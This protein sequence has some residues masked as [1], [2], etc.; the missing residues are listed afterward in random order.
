MV[1]SYQRDKDD[2][3]RY[4]IGETFFKNPIVLF[5]VRSAALALF[6]YALVYAFIYPDPS[7]NHFTTALFWSFFWP[8][9]MFL[10]LPTLGAYFCSICPLS[11]VG[12]KLKHVKKRPLAMPRFLRNPYIS[13][14]VVL[15]VYWGL[16]FA[17]PGV[18]SQ[19][20]AVAAFYTFFALMAFGFFYFFKDMSYCAYI[21]P[22]SSIR[23]AFS[24]ISF[25][26]LGTY[27]DACS[28]CKTFECAK[29]CEFGQSP[30]NFDR[31][32]SMA[33]CI[34]CMDC[35]QACEAVSFKINK[36]GFSLL[37]PIKRARAVDVWSYLLLFA[38][39][40]LTLK[41]ITLYNSSQIAPMLPWV[42]LSHALSLAFP[43]SAVDFE[44]VTTLLFSVG[45]T[46]MTV[47]A[48]FFAASKILDTAFW[49]LFAEVGYAYA[50]LPLIASF[51]Y[52]ATSFFTRYFHSVVNGFIEAFA[53]PFS[54]IEPLARSDAPWLH[55]FVVF[56][57]IAVIWTVWLIWHRVSMAAAGARFPARVFSALSLAVLPLGYMLIC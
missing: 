18:F 40:T 27:Q 37:S 39:M 7:D 47:F 34:L 19:P 12:K 55:Y 10:S 21:C 44:A 24:R 32:S 20:I 45:V 38:F 5:I 3:F 36:P 6:V 14:G 35:A 50:P 48:A 23:N 11:F 9:F 33:D 52:A 57:Y 30:F 25:M 42:Q 31:N 16:F 26:W 2:L 28:S 56:D 41:V 15:V 29:A 8:F 22:V 17:F 43:D 54:F 4:K 1:D 51:G 49:T 13:L 46:L 53:L